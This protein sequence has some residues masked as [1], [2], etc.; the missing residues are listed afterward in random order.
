MSSLELLEHVIYSGG[1]LLSSSPLLQ[2]NTP[3]P[4][5][6]DQPVSRVK[7]NEN[8]TLNL[9]EEGME[10]EDEGEGGVDV[11]TSLSH[12]GKEKGNK[13]TNE[14]MNYSDRQETSSGSTVN[15]KSKNT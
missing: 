10:D 9:N 6:G 3:P 7:W 12:G 8:R 4:H 5:K 11:E 13:A 14:G 2:H 15:D 1:N